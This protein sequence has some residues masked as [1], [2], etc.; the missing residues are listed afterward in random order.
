MLLSENPRQQTEHSRDQHTSGC[1][2]VDS[3]LIRENPCQQTQYSRDQ[4]TSGCVGGNG[5]LI[6][7]IPR[8]QTEHSRNQHT[9]GGVGVRVLVTN[10]QQIE[11]Q[12]LFNSSKCIVCRCHKNVHHCHKHS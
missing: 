8:Q 4:H 12:N 10:S 11:L 7:E 9:S 3:M 6:R 5:V 1:L 2:E